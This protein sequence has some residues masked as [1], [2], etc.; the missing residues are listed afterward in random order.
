[1]YT[2]NLI[3]YIEYDVYVVM[4][5]DIRYLTSDYTID[6]AYDIPLRNKKVPGLIKDKTMV[7]S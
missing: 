6:N 5:R 7:R 3:Y 2:D 1:M 4:K